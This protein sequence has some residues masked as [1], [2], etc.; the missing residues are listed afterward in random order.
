[1]A[2]KPKI[3]QFLKFFIFQT[4][5]KEY[6]HLRNF[7]KR[8]ELNGDNKMSVEASK[9]IFKEEVLNA[10]KDPGLLL[11]LSMMRDICEC[12]ESPTMAVK[13]RIIKVRTFK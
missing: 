12:F 8:A 4:L 11:Y 2:Q 5:A 10:V 1:M 3:E 13:Q 9:R 7:L 6:P